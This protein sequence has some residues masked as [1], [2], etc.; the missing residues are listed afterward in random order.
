MLFYK[1][2]THLGLFSISCLFALKVTWNVVLHLKE[3]SLKIQKQGL[4]NSL[5]KKS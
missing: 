1:F 2:A 3:N 4:K 5:T